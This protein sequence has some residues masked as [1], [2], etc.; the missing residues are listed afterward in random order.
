MGNADGGPI[1]QQDNIQSTS[2]SQHRPFRHE[3]FERRCTEGGM[4]S[5]P[6]ICL[7]TPK[8]DTAS[9]RKTSQ[10]GGELIMDTSHWL[11]QC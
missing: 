11:D 5:K 1:C 6:E 7:L 8:Y 9:P 4:A 2:V 10:V 3:S